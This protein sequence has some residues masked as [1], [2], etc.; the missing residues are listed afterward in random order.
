MQCYD[1]SFNDPFKNLLFDEILLDEAEKGQG[2]EVLRL[3]ESPVPFIVLGR[4]CRIEENVIA[5]AV[6]RDGVPVLRRCSGGGTV[7][8]G[9][10]CLNFSLILSKQR[11]GLQ[12]IHRSYRYVLDLIAEA[13][14]PLGVRAVFRPVCDLAFASSERKFSGNAQ[15]RLRKFLLHHGTLLYDFDLDLIPRYLRMP[16][17]V[18]D[19]RK[20][21]SHR[22]FVANLRLERAALKRALCACFLS[23]NQP[24]HNRLVPV[25][26][27]RLKEC[28]RDRSAAMSVEMH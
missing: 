5:E 18:P 16:P 28:V 25:L 12:Q 22:D 2:G 13:L 11:P 6:C 27:S 4:V 8:Q 9:P 15:R 17:S 19:Y 10:G 20:R 26:F 3:W 7:L 23:G 14:I 1:L 24:V 21:R